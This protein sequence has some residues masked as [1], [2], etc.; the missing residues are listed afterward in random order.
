M[1]PEEKAIESREFDILIVGGGPA[2]LSTWLHLQREDPGLAARTLLIEKAV[3]PRDKLCGGGIIPQAD[4]VL[5]DLGVDLQVPAVLIQHVD[6]VFGPHRLRWSDPHAF[7]VVRR[8]QFD[9]A[10]ARAAV[11]RGL[12][13]HEDEAFQRFERSG[14]AVCVETS[15]GRYRVRALVGADGALS[16]VRRAMNLRETPRIS[17]LLEI[18]T[19]TSPRN[20]PQFSSGTVVFDFTS[21]AAGLQ[22]YIWDFPCLDAGI[23]SFNYGIFDSRVCPARPL[24]KLHK[25]FAEALQARECLQVPFTWS[26]HPE[27]WFAREGVYAQPNI[28]LVGDAAG[29]EPTFGEGI[30]YALRYGRS[31]ALYLV[32]SCR[33][34]DF[35]F[36][37]YRDRLLAS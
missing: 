16:S 21:V 31:A 9:Q 4:Q 5:H 32:Y 20:L 22:G 19:P 34:G 15:R 23:P 18:L 2:G 13:L 11:E 36:Q 7:R 6:Y 37:D 29:V 8:S 14:E 12:T 10:L 33:R 35:S 24:A 17:R 26:S 3:Y 28:L 25:V 27:R 30:S 1:T